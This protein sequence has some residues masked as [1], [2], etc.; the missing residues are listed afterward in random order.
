[1]QAL[2][3]AKAGGKKPGKGAKGVVSPKAKG[4][5]KEGNAKDEEED[6]TEQCGVLS[7]RPPP[8]WKRL[9]NRG[10]GGAQAP[11]ALR[12]LRVKST[13]HDSTSI[14]LLYPCKVS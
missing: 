9:L 7:R 2:A 10:F 13:R 3:Q 5:A 12:E 14:T 8:R 1:M 11:V 6:E 4:K